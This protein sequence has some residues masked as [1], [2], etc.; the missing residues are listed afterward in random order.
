MSGFTKGLEKVQVTLKW[1]PSPSGE[2][3]NDLDIVAATYTADDPYGS[4]DYLV[5]FDNRAP[6]GTITLDRDSRNGQGFGA[7]EA[8][9]LEL[10][11]LADTYARVVV[12]VAIQQDEGRRT[13]G[14]V[15]GS[16]VKVLDGITE[17]A[18][19]DFAGVG[20]STAAVVAEFVR[21]EGGVWEFQP[22][23]RGYDVAPAEFTETMG[24]AR[25]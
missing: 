16:S 22:A 12:G 4:P 15:T 1:D 9:T 18:E 17:L 7:D 21:G 20:E 25:G 10:Y 6:D 3:D 14:Q 11:R 24:R 13:F 5:H 19:N 8:M 23:L 2:P